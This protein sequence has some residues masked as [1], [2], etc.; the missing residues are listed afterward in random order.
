M[1]ECSVS[2]DSTS[3]CYLWMDHDIGYPFDNLSVSMNLD[4]HACS[5]CSVSSNSISVC[6][7]WMDHDIVIR[8]CLHRCCF[9]LF[10]ISVCVNESM[11]GTKEADFV[12]RLSTSK[13]AICPHELVICEFCSFDIGV[14]ELGLSCLLMNLSLDSTSVWYLWMDQDIGYPS[15][16]V[17][18]LL[19]CSWNLVD[20]PFPV[21]GLFGICAV[22]SW[23]FRQCGHLRS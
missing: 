18:S 14:N 13:F 21:S 16:S 20:C 11:D 22:R 2:L 8:P 6:C 3:V 23:F 7:L 10:D 4:Y 9:R 19:I 17:V 5:C 15:V 1:C 12:Q